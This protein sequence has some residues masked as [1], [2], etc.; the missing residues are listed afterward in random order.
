MAVRAAR[1][2]RLAKPVLAQ[3]AVV[4]LAATLA[5]RAAATL[6]SV[7]AVRLST[8][9][10]VAFLVVSLVPLAPRVITDLPRSSTSA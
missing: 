4:L 7:V 10:L 8:P 6:A 3:R 5:P 1:L 9:V 2:V